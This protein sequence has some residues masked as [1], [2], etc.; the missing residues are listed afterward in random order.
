M[1]LMTLMLALFTIL[2]FDVFLFFIFVWQYRSTLLEPLCHMAFLFIRCI[3]NVLLF[4]NIVKVL[5]FLINKIRKKICSRLNPSKKNFR[6]ATLRVISVSFQIFF[7]TQQS[8][9]CPFRGTSSLTIEFS[10]SLGIAICSCQALKKVL[11]FQRLHPFF[12][13]FPS[14]KHV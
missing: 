9:W 2:L 6:K 5:L 10:Q 13:N 12:I 11:Y 4:L 14:S 7:Q 3:V 8:T 1:T